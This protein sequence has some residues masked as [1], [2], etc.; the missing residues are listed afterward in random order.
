MAVQE[1]YPRSSKRSTDTGDNESQR[2]DFKLKSMHFEKLDLHENIA[3][4]IHMNIFS[5]QKHS[6]CFNSIFGG[7]NWKTLNGITNVINNKSGILM[8]EV[9][10]IK[11]IRRQSDTCVEFLYLCTSANSFHTRKIRFRVQFITG[12][13]QITHMPVVS[14]RT[15][16]KEES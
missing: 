1:I 16:N 8:H 2:L 9:I 14:E 12:Q 4:C 3:Y 7:S 6:K 5:Q 13:S 11:M 10:K 15:T